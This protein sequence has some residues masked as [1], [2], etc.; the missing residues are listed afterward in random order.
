MPTTFLNLFS[1]ECLILAIYVFAFNFPIECIILNKRLYS[2]LLLIASLT[3]FIINLCIN[4]RSI[5]SRNL[6]LIVIM[7]V[8]LTV[9]LITLIFKSHILTFDNALIQEFDFPDFTP[10]DTKTIELVMYDDS[11]DS[12]ILFRLFRP[13]YNISFTAYCIEI[14]DDNI[15]KTYKCIS[16]SY[17]PAVHV[18]IENIFLFLMTVLAPFFLLLK[19]DSIYLGSISILFIITA[20][21]HKLVSKNNSHRFT[22]MLTYISEFLILFLFAFLIIK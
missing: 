13:A 19:N 8:L 12:K 11:T 9:L 20:L 22:S 21:L 16:Y 1:I 18:L 6:I 2:L 14:S 7:S 3:A 17:I 4:T 5:F 15:E 10:A